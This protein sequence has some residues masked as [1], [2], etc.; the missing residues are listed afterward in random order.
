LEIERQLDRTIGSDPKFA[1]WYYKQS[2]ISESI[3]IKSIEQVQGDERDIVLISAAYGRNLE[4]KFYQFFGPILTHQ[5]EN[6]LNVLMSRAREKIYFVSSIKASDIQLRDSSSRGL[7]LFRKLFEFL[8]SKLHKSEI[9][10]QYL[11]NY[12]EYFLNPFRN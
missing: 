6:R 1:R 7:V 2:S 11:D 8:E 10:T 12:W 3:F 4:G 5:G 9:Q